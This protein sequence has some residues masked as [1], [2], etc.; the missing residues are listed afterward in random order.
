[1]RKCLAVSLVLVI[2]LGIGNAMAL[3]QNETV[4]INAWI[5]SS[6][7]VTNLP[8]IGFAPYV[9]LG[10]GKNIGIT[11]SFAA[12]TQEEAWISLKI[13]FLGG[14]LFKFEKP[15]IEIK[16]SIGLY[17]AF[18]S[19]K[20]DKEN[21]NSFNFGLLLGLAIPARINR[22]LIYFEG[23]TGIGLSSDISLKIFVQLGIKI[24]LKSFVL[25]F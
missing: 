3:S 22:T 16:Y 2:F 18:L 15:E 12:M 7:Q 20:D 8:N 6:V 24:Q 25:T 9:S 19:Q 4:V 21:I 23:G 17:G 14:S 10:I 5:G 13:N 11:Y 1:M